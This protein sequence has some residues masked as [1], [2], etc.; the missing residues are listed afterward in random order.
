MESAA[1]C[2]H[3]K[4]HCLPA[5]DILRHPVSCSILEISRDEEGQ[6]GFTIH[7]QKPVC[8]AEVEQGSDALDKGVTVGAAILKV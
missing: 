4:Y 2:S 8:I 3:V 5:I 6:L 1:F 7:G